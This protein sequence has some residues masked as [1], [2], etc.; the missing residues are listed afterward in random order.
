MPP[1]STKSRIEFAGVPMTDSPRPD[2][3]P[4]AL[5]DVRVLDVTQFMAGPFC[6]TM[7]ADLGADVIK[8]EPPSGDS[9]RKAR[10]S[11]RSIAASAASW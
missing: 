7:L 2:H 5:D 4:R 3:T 10:P 6:A 9:A 1:S 11:T 8:I